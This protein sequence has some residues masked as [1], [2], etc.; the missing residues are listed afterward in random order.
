MPATPVEWLQAS[1]LVGLGLLLFVVTPWFIMRSR[2][3]MRDAV[4]QAAFQLSL[5]E[6]TI[7]SDEWEIEEGYGGEF[8]GVGLMVSIATKMAEAPVTAVLIVARPSQPAPFAY[9]LNRVGG[10]CQPEIRHPDESF[11]SRVAITS[12]DP[13]RVIGLF[14]DPALRE[15]IAAFLAEGAG[16]AWIDHEGAG[17]VVFDA[18]FKGAARVLERARETATLAK[19]LC[20]RAAAIG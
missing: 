1:F 6:S 7:E 16:S 20:E 11:T 15:R 19:A 17:F 18:H 13:A 8:Q 5:P 9:E 2:R 14:E 3:R 10:I 12:A 4:R